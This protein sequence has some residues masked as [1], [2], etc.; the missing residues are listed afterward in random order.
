MSSASRRSAAGG[1]TL[2]VRRL[3]VPCLVAAALV[4]AGC[5]GD[6]AS[7]AEPTV[8]VVE[9][10]EV[11]AAP[12][13]DSTD[14]SVP[15]PPPTSADD[16]DSTDASVPPPPP[17][18]S[19]DDEAQPDEPEVADGAPPKSDAAAY[20]QYLVSQAIDLYENEGLGALLAEVNSPAGIDGQWYVFVVD[21]DDTVIGHYDVD[22]LGTDLNGWIGTDVNGYVFGTEMLTATESGKWV[23]YVFSNPA[24]GTL[25]DEDSFE[26]KNA[27]VVRHDGLL[28][29]SGWYVDTEEFAPQLF[30]EAAE[31][32]RSGGLE[33]FLEFSNEPGGV[34][35]G[36]IP[37]AEYY[38]RT[39]TLDG[40][41]TGI[42]AAPDGTILAHIDPGLIGTDIEDLLGSAVRNVTA[43]GGWITADDNP[44]GTGPETMR[45]W[46]IDVDG[47]LI[48]GGWYRLAEG[49]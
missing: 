27:W 4:A 1:S 39:D 43:E 36:L 13:A 7:S 46:L 38:N 45:M 44:E 16:A 14:A 24:S 47:T 21:S 23:P 18:T 34:N 33:A 8:P 6:D 17:P 29:G 26:F 20:T 12:S 40:L 5:S 48:G 35:T 30:S 2:A 10:E 49:G 37:L 19:A 42:A 41:F 9:T 11:T 3:L 32:F 22:R 15:P 31:H 28:F 25:G